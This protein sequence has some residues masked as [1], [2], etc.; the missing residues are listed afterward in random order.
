MG[1]Y[2]INDGADRFTVHDDRG[3]VVASGVSLVA[4]IELVHEGCRFCDAGQNHTN[5]A[6][7][8]DRRD[9]RDRT[10]TIPRVAEAFNKIERRTGRARSCSSNRA[11][12]TPTLPSLHRTARSRF[13]PRRSTGPT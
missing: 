3:T 2:M 1:R 4:A 6:V 10:T 12:L 11:A 8:S 9:P 5:D 13:S 7:R